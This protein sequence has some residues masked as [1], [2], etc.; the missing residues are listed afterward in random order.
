[1]ATEVMTR[2]SAGLPVAVD[3]TPLDRVLAMMESGQRVDVEVLERLVALQERAAERNARAAYFEALSL[4]QEECPEIRKSRTAEIAT[5]GGGKYEYTFAPLEE[6]T[7]TIRPILKRH[8]LSYSWTTAAGVLAGVL[9]V[10][11]ILRHVDGHQEEASF[12]VPTGTS[13]AMSEAQKSGAA[14]TYGRRQ[15]L[16]AV[17]GLTTADPDTDAPSVGRSPE[18]IDAQQAKYLNMLLDEVAARVSRGAFFKWLAVSSVEDVVAADYVK[19]VEFLE[20][21]R[22]GAA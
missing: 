22:K 18:K 13:A 8:G 17:L 10:K 9:D 20:R 5:R 21:K 6:I 19:A 12:P 15:S 16:I 4:F 2:E 3:A 7:R 14:L 1:M 11:C